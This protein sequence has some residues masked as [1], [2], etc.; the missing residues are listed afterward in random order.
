LPAGPVEE[1]RLCRLRE[2]LVDFTPYPPEYGVDLARLDL[3]DLAVDWATASLAGTERR[4]EVEAAFYRMVDV[5]YAFTAHAKAHFNEDQR[6]RITD[7]A[8]AAAQQLAPGFLEVMRASI[9]CLKG[10]DEKNFCRPLFDLLYPLRAGKFIEHIG[11]AD[12]HNLIQTCAGFSM[13]NELF[14][15]AIG[16][17]L[18]AVPIADLAAFPAPVVRGVIQQHSAVVKTAKDITDTIIAALKA[19]ELTVKDNKIVK[20]AER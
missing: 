1:I 5:M 19:G 12:L 20:V 13:A 3:A 14:T 15:V 6:R 10:L 11:V 9:R 7:D 8:Q 16:R 4:S 2:V 18:H 17:P